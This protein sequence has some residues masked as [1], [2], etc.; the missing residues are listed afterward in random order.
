MNYEKI[1]QLRPVFLPEGTVTAANASN[2]SDGA[3]ALLLVEKKTA[4]SLNLPVVGKI[5]A[6]ADAAREP[7]WF[8]TAPSLAIP[9][10]LKIAGLKLN[11]IDFLKL[12]KLFQRL[13]WQIS[14]CY[15]SLKIN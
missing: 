7:L 10:A 6:F 12:M 8:T 2:I 14:N 1:P 4:L 3:S 5:T 9:K 15:K 13:H 11:D